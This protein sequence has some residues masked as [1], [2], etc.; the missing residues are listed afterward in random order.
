MDYVKRRHGRR[1]DDPQN[2]VHRVGFAGGH[3][4]KMATHLMAVQMNAAEVTTPNVMMEAI[5]HIDGIAFLPSE[6]E[7]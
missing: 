2:G 1:K 5:N 4:C 6:M 7:R 3:G